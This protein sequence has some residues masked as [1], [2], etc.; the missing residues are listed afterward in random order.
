M[1]KKALEV[2]LKCLFAIA[3]TLWAY[4]LQCHALAPLS[5]RIIQPDRRRI[6]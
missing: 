2:A 3:H 4:L 1:T 5:S 6:K